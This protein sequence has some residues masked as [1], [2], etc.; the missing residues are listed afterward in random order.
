M[1]QRI[2]L[3]LI[4]LLVMA[5]GVSAAT[6]NAD[7]A[8]SSVNFAVRHL[9][10]STVN[11]K[12]GEFSGTLD[13]DGQDMSTGTVE[14]AVQI[15]SVDTDNED[16]DKHLISPEFFD[17]T[18]FPTM[19]FKST[20]VILGDGNAFKLVGDLTIRG[21]TKAVTFDCE[22]YGTANFM[23]TNKAGFS[24]KVEIDRQDFGVSWSKS[25][26]GGGLIVSD[27]VKISLELEFNEAS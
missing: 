21:V 8:H 1:V 14:F 6:W 11:G 17:A 12:F 18:Q 25:L 2:A 5:A 10:I 7:P 26:D 27:N 9:V 15:G 16:R 4:V 23:K 13:W 22:F 19:T 24:A 3:T 20:K